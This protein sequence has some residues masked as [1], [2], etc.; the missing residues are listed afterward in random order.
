MNESG[1]LPVLGEIVACAGWLFEVIDLDGKR[2]DKI[3]ARRDA[4]EIGLNL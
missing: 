1:H 3:L 4:S 2:I